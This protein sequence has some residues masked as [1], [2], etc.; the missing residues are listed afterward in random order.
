[1]S[2][3]LSDHELLME[4]REDVAWIKNHLSS[5]PTRK[6]IYGVLATIITIGIGVL[7]AII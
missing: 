7:S 5:V 1:M 3:G 2:N 6:E 4:V